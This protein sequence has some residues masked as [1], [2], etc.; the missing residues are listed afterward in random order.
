MSFNSTIILKDIREHRDAL[1]KGELYVVDLL[2]E[3][4]NI[5]EE[6]EGEK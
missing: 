2:A 6:K 4:I 3:I 1:S 5:L